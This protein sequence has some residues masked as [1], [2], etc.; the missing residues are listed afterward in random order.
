MDKELAQKALEVIEHEA[1]LLG[2]RTEEKFMIEAKDLGDIYSYAHVAVGRC[3]V[4]HKDWIDKLNKKHQE[5]K[6]EKMI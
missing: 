1:A 4:H 3:S 2:C 5:L 6:D